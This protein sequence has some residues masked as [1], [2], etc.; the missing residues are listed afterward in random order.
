MQDSAV[1]SNFAIEEGFASIV[2]NNLFI[3]ISIRL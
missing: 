1:T 3:Y 2:R